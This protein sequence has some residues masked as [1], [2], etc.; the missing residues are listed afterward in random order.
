M[1]GRQGSPLTMLAFVD[2]EYRVPANHPRLTIN[3]GADK[4][5]PRLWPG[6]DRVTAKLASLYV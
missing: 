2:L 4:A 6:F 1:C 5:L 3:S